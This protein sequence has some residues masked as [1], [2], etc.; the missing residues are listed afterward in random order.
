[1]ILCCLVVS[2]C[3]RTGTH[4]TYIYAFKF[5]DLLKWISFTIRVCVYNV[6]MFEY[7]EIYKKLSR[8]SLRDV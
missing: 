4:M 7:D 1:M 3:V 2:V 8:S 6:Y 5:H